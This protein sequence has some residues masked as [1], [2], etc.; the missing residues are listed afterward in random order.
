MADGL[1]QLTEASDL[2]INRPEHVSGAGSERKRS[3]AGAQRARNWVS[4]SGA[5][6]RRAKKTMERERSEGHRRRKVSKSVWAG[7][8]ARRRGFDAEDVEIETPKASKGWGVGRRCR[9]PIGWGLERELC[10]SKFF[11]FF[12][13]NGM[14]WCILGGIF[15]K[16][17]ACRI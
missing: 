2:A 6:S 12:I 10:P 9:L 4:G 8:E 1:I 14:L 11:Q 16:R 15:V 7:K 13:W 5:V 17:Y 3:G